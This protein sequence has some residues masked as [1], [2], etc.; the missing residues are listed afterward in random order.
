M[1]VVAVV[2]ERLGVVEAAIGV[3]R[4]KRRRRRVVAWSVAERVLYSVFCVSIGWRGK[5][6]ATM[7]ARPLL[8][9]ILPRGELKSHQGLM[10]L[11]SQQNPEW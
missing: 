10:W 7:E 5:V 11:E 1:P 4:W 9:N 3:I 2:G 8:G 6:G